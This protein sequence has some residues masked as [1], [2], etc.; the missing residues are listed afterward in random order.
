DRSFDSVRALALCKD[1]DDSERTDA[2]VARFARLQDTL[3]DKLLPELLK[4][5]AEPVGSA[6]DNLDRA[7]KLGL[8]RSADNWIAA[9]KL[10]NRMVHEYVREPSELAEALNAG[11]ALVP[12]LTSF[13]VAVQRYC[14]ARGLLQHP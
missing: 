12:L 11:H 5:L 10:R 14:D 3:A 13:A 9:R 6:I 1:I 2:F 4:A 7:E 8:L